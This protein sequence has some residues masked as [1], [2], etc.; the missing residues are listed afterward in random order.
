MKKLTIAK[1]FMLTSFILFLTPL[2]GLFFSNESNITIVQS[3]FISLCIVGGIIT[4]LIGINIL[5][6]EEYKQKWKFT[7]KKYIVEQ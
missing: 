2:M 1:N 6:G 4:F 5:I 7:K 3:V